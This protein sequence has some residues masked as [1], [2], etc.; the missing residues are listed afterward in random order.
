MKASVR[1]AF[2]GINEP[3]EGWVSTAYPDQIGLVTVGLGNLADPLPLMLAI[4]FERIGGGLASDEEK[5]AEFH[6]VKALVVPAGVSRWR[7]AARG[8][9][10]HLPREAG[11]A[12]VDA[13]LSANEGR[14]R[15]LLANWDDMP[16]DAQAM[17]LSWAWAVGPAA[18]FPKMIAALRAGDYLAAA[19]E[20]TINPDRESVH[21]RNVGN[22]VMLRNA[23]YVV[24][25]GMSLDELYY[26]RDLDPVSA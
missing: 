10:I 1:A 21:L 20:C 17:A 15:A 8:A 14:L 26:P 2:F 11:A 5:T 4:P 7:W 18:R 9:T 24:A 12:L 6:R 3:W 13:K 23:A 19:K 16:A 22:R 25:E